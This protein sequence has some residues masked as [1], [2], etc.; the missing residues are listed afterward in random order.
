MRKIWF[1]GA[2][3]CALAGCGGASPPSV[4]P[5]SVAILS[6]TAET[7]TEEL[8]WSGNIVPAETAKLSFKISGVIADVSVRAGDA[9]QSGQVLARLN[10]DDCETQVRAAEAQWRA[11]TL[12]AENILPAG[13]AQ[14]KA[15]LDL[16][17]A[18]YARALELY[19][20]GA[21]SAV[22]LEEIAAKKTADEAVHTQALEALDIGRAEAERARAAYDFALSSLA[23]TEIKSPWDGV[24][25]QVI[26]AAGESTNAG[27][28]VLV[29]GQTAEMW[30]EIG[31]TDEE[32]VRL[33][34]GLAAEVYV[35]G[36]EDTRAG[37]LEE[38]GALADSLTRNFTGRVRL[39]GTD[40]RLRAGMI[41]RVSIALPGYEGILAP[42]SSVLHLADGE[43]VYIYD[44]AAGT[45]L[46]RPVETGETRGDRV[47]ILS[48]LAPGDSLIVEGQFKLRDGEKVTP[49]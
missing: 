35:Y 23:A 30:V 33:T 26:A 14:A 21:I 28:P 12:Q 10:P 8:V 27:Y 11:A 37:V 7:L 19:E 32:S 45:A 47:E 42:V 6:V 39:P 36:P 25:L 49:R 40:G 44:A 48:G 1:I 43:A 4:P 20:A 24:V 22:S 13:L 29:L 2:V 34:P 16:T 38:I 31:L 41:A 5:Q 46:R 17:L 3:L 18:N 15:Q 9:V